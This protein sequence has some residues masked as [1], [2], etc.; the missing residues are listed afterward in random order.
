MTTK[1]LYRDGEYLAL[2]VPAGTESNDPRLVGDIPVVCQTDRDADG[3]ASCALKGVFMLEVTAAADMAVGDPVYIDAAT[4][5]LSD[6]AADHLFGFLIS[7][8]PTG[9][10]EVP[11][12]LAGPTA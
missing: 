11:V 4:F 9:T 3:E 1:S 8:L 12:L 2:P 7:A 6:S 10:D 5:A